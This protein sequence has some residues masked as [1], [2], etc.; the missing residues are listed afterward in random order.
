[1]SSHARYESDPN[2]WVDKV[3]KEYLW[4]KQREIN[5]S[6]VAHR[7]TAVKSAHDTGKSFDM[8]RLMGWW[9]DTKPDPFVVTTAPTW[10]Q[11]NSI[12]WREARRAHRKGK[13]GGRI[14]LDAEWYIGSDELV[15]FGRKPADYD[16]AAFQGIHALNV[17]VIIDEACGV[18]QQIFEAAD[19]LATNQRA[20]VVAI[21]NPDD[22][23][24]YFA[25]VCQPGSGWNVIKISAYDTPAFTDEEVPDYLYDY[26]VSEQWVDERVKR[27]GVR[28]PIFI[29][30]VLGEFPDISDDTLLTPR[31]LRQAQEQDL[32]P[33]PGDDPTYGFDI[34][35]FGDAWSAAARAFGGRVRIVKSWHL[36]PTNQSVNEITKVLNEEED[37]GES[38]TANID[39]IG[40]GAGVYDQAIE[41]KLPVLPHNGSEQPND[42]ERFYNKRAE[43]WWHVRE[44]AEAG[45][46]DLPEQGEDDELIAQLGSIKW[47]VM[48]GGKIA[49]ESKEDMRKRGLPSPDKA[50]AVMM[51]LSPGLSI[52]VPMSVRNKTSEGSLTNDLLNKQM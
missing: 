25:S 7:Y 46:L 44:L 21:G 14:N 36:M 49:I 20:R 18:P 39:V 13:L 27:W 37:W 17:L 3:V 33:K 50:D 34:S 24:S 10:K 19:S 5:D 51:A 41:Q 30:K 12:L 11:V 45:E 52:W 29:S 1:L 28:S 8:A 43:D 22:P 48:P 38:S 40:L 35:R 23:A 42:T 9:I 6:V 2:G 47:K 16:Q 15:A 32:Y 4:S 31:M 26:L